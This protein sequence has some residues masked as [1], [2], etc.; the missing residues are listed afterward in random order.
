M[1]SKTLFTTLTMIGFAS[2]VTLSSFYKTTNQ[3]EDK[4]DK[5]E[6]VSYKSNSKQTTQLGN[7]TLSTAFEND[8]YTNNN[9]EGNIYVELKANK[10]IGNHETHTPLNISVVIDRSG[11]MAGDK[12]QNAK[13]AAKYIVDQLSGD[14]YLSVVIYDGEIT[15]LQPTIA[16]ANKQS[17]KNKS[18]AITDRGGTNLMGGAMKG[19]EEV[20]R[21]YKSGYINRVL[22]LSD[23]QANEGI[24]DP[25]QIEKIIRTQNK[26]NGISIST[27]GLGNDYNED[28]MTAMAETG[29]GNY[30][31][32]NDAEKIAS[33]FKKE[34]NG[35]MEVVAQNTTLTITVPDFVNIEKVY[36]YK[37]DQVGNQLTIHVHDI[38]SEETKGL[39]I[40]YRIQNGNNSA[41]KFIAKANYVDAS[42]REKKSL[43]TSNKASF[44]N[45]LS[46][47]N[48]YF[49]EWAS[50]QVAL[51]VSN[52][53]LE[54]AMKEVDKGNYQQARVIVQENTIYMSKKSKLIEKSPELKR[55]TEN[56]NAYDENIKNVESMAEADVKYLQKSTKSENYMIRNKR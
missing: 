43:A 14:D 45:Q 29:T 46:V 17:I 19:Y 1:K 5:D 41:V 34:L 32:I 51:Y 37:Y 44:T 10:Y 11:S 26:E 40:K 2:I 3:T 31:F 12:M 50:A 52:E 16:V 6:T 35:L 39:L 48:D 22:L 47:Y 30:Y 36:G 56:N 55:A 21:F 7:L 42:N 49:N 4:P 15:L 13:K 28:L 53:K 25:K 23:G 9:R 54:V 33:I 18:D 20:K 27:F 8:Y 38:F 24:T